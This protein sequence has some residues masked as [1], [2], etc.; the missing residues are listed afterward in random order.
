MSQSSQDAIRK[1]AQEVLDCFQRS[2]DKKDGKPDC[3]CINC[4]SYRRAKKL[5]D[6]IDKKMFLLL[7]FVAY[8]KPGGQS[9]SKH[10]IQA[11]SKKSAK[12]IAKE[13]LPG[14]YMVENKILVNE[15]GRAW[16]TIEEKV[17]L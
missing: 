12:T 9:M 4:E 15:L 10:I 8:P 5:V 3:M 17:I 6:S 16:D 11:I 2:I 14:A 7:Y 1:A 13:R